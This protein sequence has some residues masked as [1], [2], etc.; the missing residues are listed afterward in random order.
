MDRKLF[1]FF[2]AIVL[3]VVCWNHFTSENLESPAAIFIALYFFI[4]TA[5]VHRFLIKANAKSPQSFVRIYMAS[6]TLR[7]FLNLIVIIAYAL[8]NRSGLLIFVVTYLLIYF[9]FLIF[10]IISLQK[11]LKRP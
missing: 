4:L 11:D 1:F 6:M 10:E 9:A 7:F 8:I 5:I 3:L 2:L